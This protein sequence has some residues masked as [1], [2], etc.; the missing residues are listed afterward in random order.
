MK[1]KA[2]ITA[3]AIT[4]VVV[5]GHE[6]ARVLLPLVEIVPA[7]SFFVAKRK[8]LIRSLNKWNIELLSEIKSSNE[9]FQGNSE[10]FYSLFE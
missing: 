8:I 10:S 5:E 3:G 9:R 6:T 1:D 4:R 7:S 2:K